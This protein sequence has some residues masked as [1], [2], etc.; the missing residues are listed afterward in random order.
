MVRLVNYN[1]LE[2]LPRVLVH[3]LCLRYL[4]EQILDD[5]P[6]VIAHVR[7]GDFEVVHRGDDVELELAVAAGL[8]DAG[9]DLDF[10]DAC[11]VEFFEGCYDA[12]LFAG[13]R[14]AV[15]EEVG[16]VAALGLFIASAEN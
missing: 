4:L 7:R 3:L 13:A 16:E 1:D 12:C 14:G 9:V 15:E 2:P 11:A 6:V 8:E 10:L 5:H